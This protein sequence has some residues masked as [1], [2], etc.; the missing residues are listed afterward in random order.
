MNPTY[1]REDPHLYTALVLILITYVSGIISKSFMLITIAFALALGIAL[2]CLIVKQENIELKELKA[3]KQTKRM[4]KNGDA[5]RS[6]SAIK[7][8]GEEGKKVNIIPTT[9]GMNLTEIYSKK[10]GIDSGYMG[11]ILFD[12]K[13]KK[14]VLVD[15]HK[16]MQM[17]LD[18]LKEAFEMT[19]RHWKPKTPKEAD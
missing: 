8:L 5:R 19:E 6:Y 9:T 11:A 15:L 13:W 2:V 7:L 17:S 10:E 14:Y 1:K 3:K 4:N 16:D 12:K 18:C